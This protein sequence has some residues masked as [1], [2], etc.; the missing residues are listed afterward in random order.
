MAFNWLESKKQCIRK[1]KERH[2]AY[3]HDGRNQ[4]AISLK[5]KIERCEDALS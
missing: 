1:M 4:E 3:A 2:R 5:K